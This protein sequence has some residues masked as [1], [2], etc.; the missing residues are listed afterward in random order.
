MNNFKK[1][2]NQ[3]FDPKHINN[4]KQTD[5]LKNLENLKTSWFEKLIAFIVSISAILAAIYSIMTYYK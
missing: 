5:Y 4:L 2:F 3:Q 1:I